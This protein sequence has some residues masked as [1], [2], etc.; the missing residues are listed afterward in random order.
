MPVSEKTQG[1]LDQALKAIQQ[2]AQH[3]LPS[4]TLKTIYQAFDDL[5]AETAKQAHNVLAVVMA[6]FAL[7][8]VEAAMRAH[9]DRFQEEIDN[10]DVSSPITWLASMEKIVRGELKSDD[11]AF[12]ES[13]YI[14]GN[15]EESFPLKLKAETALSVLYYAMQVIDQGW[16]V[17]RRGINI[18]TKQEIVLRHDADETAAEMYAFVHD[19]VTEAMP[20]AEI[21]R[22][23]PA[24]YLTFWTWWLSEAVP[25][26]WDYAEQ[27]S[28]APIAITFPAA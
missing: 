20:V 21:R 3:Q 16:P 8:Y 10:P 15:S 17:V 19:E 4:D 26:A 23:D 2:D 11:E 12:M 24:R 18:R 5:G 9:P 22:T 1:L 13:A 27:H 25:Y 14:A 28:T 6:K 7:P